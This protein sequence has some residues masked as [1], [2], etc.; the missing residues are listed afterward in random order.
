[1]CL[2][3]LSRNWP[4]KQSNSVRKRKRRTVKPLKVIQGHLGHQLKAGMR[5]NWHFISCRFG[6]TAA[7]IVQIFICVFEPHFGGLETTY[8]V[9]FGLA[10]K[11]AVDF[12][13]ALIEFF[14]NTNET[15][16]KVGDFARMRSLWPNISR[17]RGRPPPIILAWIVS[18]MNAL[19]FSHKETL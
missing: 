3:L 4:A 13:F 6:V 15:R 12:L 5:L 18:R 9:H 14:F 8:D 7:Y 10:G 16:S 1:M 17:R 2:Q 19:Q 11:R